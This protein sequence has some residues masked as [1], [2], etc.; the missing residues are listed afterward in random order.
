MEFAS[1]PTRRTAVLDFGPRAC[2]VPSRPFRK[3]RRLGPTW[4]RGRPLA[5]RRSRTS[6]WLRAQC[7]VP[8]RLGAGLVP[9]GGPCRFIPGSMR[10]CLGPPRIRATPRCRALRA[11]QAVR[12]PE[13]VCCGGCRRCIPLMAWMPEPPRTC[14]GWPVH[15]PRVRSWREHSVARL[16]TPWS[17]CPP[18][19]WSCLPL[20]QDLRKPVPRTLRRWLQEPGW[21]DRVGGRRFE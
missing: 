9:C 6:R 16:R 1:R 5:W 2:L 4:L 17:R 3:Q 18:T 12:S 11:G 10:R 7:A 14:R 15:C 13:A 20:D 19:A 21:L 8:E